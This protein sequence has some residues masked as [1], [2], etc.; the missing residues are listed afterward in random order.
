MTREEAIE[1]LKR[2][3]ICMETHDCKECPIHCDPMETPYDDE[4]AAAFRMAISALESKPRFI[5]H[6]DGSM[7]QIIEPCEDVFQVAE[8]VITTAMEETDKFIFETIKPYCE[9]IEE[10]EISKRDLECALAQYFHKKPCEDC[11][12]RADAI[13]GLDWVKGDYETVNKEYDRLIALPSVTPT[14]SKGEWIEDECFIRCPECSKEWSVYDNDCETFNYCPN[15]GAK[16]EGED[17][18]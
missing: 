18:E 7:E 10:R 5:V 1:I 15:C 13:N 8:K 17:K 12:S 9:A 11:I 6:D 14:R 16:M 3:A 4:M 2:E